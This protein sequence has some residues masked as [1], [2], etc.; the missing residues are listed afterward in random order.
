[1]GKATTA[2]G[3]PVCR[4][5]IVREKKR[6]SDLREK[7]EVTPPR[8][9]DEAGREEYCEVPSY[10]IVESYRFHITG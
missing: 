7:G 4:V 3:F 6:A 1:M 8:F 10:G 9:V 5:M 2:I